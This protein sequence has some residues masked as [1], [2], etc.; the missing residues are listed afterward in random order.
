MAKEKTPKVKVPAK[1]Q[2]QLFLVFLELGATT[3][4]GGYAMIPLIRE[5]IVNQ[6]GW[7]TDDELLEVTAIAESTPGPMSINLA[8]YVG[9]KKGGLLGSLLATIG[10]VIPSLVVI[11][12]V[13]LIFNQFITN[14]WVAYA[15]VGVKAAVAFLICDA[16]VGLIKK[17][18]KEAF[19]IIVLIAIT[20]IML[21]F[22]I[23]SIDFSSIY[24]ILMGG[25]LGIIFYSIV[26]AIQKKKAAKP[27]EKPEEKK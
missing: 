15:F 21:C 22:D 8:T 17:M 2:W 23:F 10:V 19:Q 24:L 13:S 7:L 26:A 9:Y 6:K 16:A 27:L 1:E 5:K 20:A 18:K 12:L 3:F 14:K 4:G 25:V 11:Y